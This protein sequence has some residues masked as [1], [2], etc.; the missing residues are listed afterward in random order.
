M[1]T[2]YNILNLIEITLPKS[3]KEYW[4]ELIAQ[5]DNE[6]MDELIRYCMRNKLSDG[7]EKLS[8]LR[9]RLF[10]GSLVVAG[11]YDIYLKHR[12]EFKTNS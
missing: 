3:I 7:L 1:R 10:K 11:A 6:I 2:T 5:Y 12:H 8:P 9:L 4:Q